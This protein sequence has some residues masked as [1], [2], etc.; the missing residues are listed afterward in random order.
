MQNYKKL[1]YFLLK[2]LK[3]HKI[4]KNI[5]NLN[6]FFDEPKFN[7][8]GIALILPKKYSDGLPP[9]TEINITASGI[10]VTNKYLA[11][12]KCIWE[13][14]ERFNLYCYREKSIKYA[15][16][17]DLIPHAIDPTVYVCDEK[18]TT[19]SRFGWVK[20]YNLTD[21]IP[22]YIPAQLIYLNYFKSKEEIK[23]SANISTG[24]AG[25]IDKETTLLRG[26]YEVIE[27][28][29]FMTVYLNSIKATRIDIGKIRNKIIQRIINKCRQYNLEIFVFNIT[30]DLAIP[31]FM[32]I[33][34]DKT[35]I[36]PAVTVGLKSSLNVLNAITGSIEES[37]MGRVMIRNEMLKRKSNDFNI[38]PKSIRTLLDRGLFWVSLKRL[39][40]LNY[41]LNQIPLPFKIHANTVKPH[42][43]LATIIDIL[44]KKGYKTYYVDITS[45][46]VKKLNYFVY[47]VIIPELQPLYLD[48]KHKELR[49]NRLK[50]VASYFGLFRYRIKSVPHPF[51]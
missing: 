41:L 17:H 38:P 5:N 37:F 18:L 4:L 7:H 51:L 9:K 12:L 46:I 14:I 29:A 10:S 33:L 21:N 36:G 19:T 6:I 50:L 48:E 25:G 30:N 13:G 15:F 11:L 32:A 2:E 23:L 35:G 22:I 44:R 16:Y 3:S 26:I 1:I 39:S 24:A 40:S 49:T 27:R 34:T 42:Q 43:E 20:G 47:K 31:V 8:Y 45:D 28:D